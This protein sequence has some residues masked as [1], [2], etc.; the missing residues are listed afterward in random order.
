MA[1][2]IRVLIFLTLSVLDKR[3]N[4]VCGHVGCGLRDFHA[5]NRVDFGST[6]LGI[7]V[8]SF[9]IYELHKDI[10]LQDSKS[11]RHNVS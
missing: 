11:Q 2:T 6:C 10:F 9:P 7:R 8:G 5:T 3:D 1:E 4:A